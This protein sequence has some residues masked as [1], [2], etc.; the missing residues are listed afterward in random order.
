M[1]K[2]KNKKEKHIVGTKEL[3][4]DIVSLALIIILG[5]YIGFRSIKYYS[6][7]TSKKKIEKDTLVQAILNNN[8]ITKSEKGLRKTNDGY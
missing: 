5:I 4:F 8:K 6:K 7:E 2:K 3:I 1:Q